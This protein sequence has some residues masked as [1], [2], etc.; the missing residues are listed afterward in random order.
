[1]SQREEWP[2]RTYGAFAFLTHD[3]LLFPN[4]STRQFEVVKLPDHTEQSD[5]D[6]E[7][8]RRIA[9]LHVS[10][11][12]RKSLFSDSDRLSCFSAPNPAGARQPVKP[13]VAPSHLPFAADSNQAIIAVQAARGGDLVLI[14][15]R[16]ALV[17]TLDAHVAQHPMSRKGLHL[18]WKEWTI[19][20]DGGTIRWICYEDGCEWTT[21][22]QRLIGIQAEQCLRIKDFNPYAVR[23]A[24]ASLKAAAVQDANSDMPQLSFAG[25]C[26]PSHNGTSLWLNDCTYKQVV[27]SGVS[28]S[29]IIE[30]G[31]E[32]PYVET[33]TELDDDAYTNVLVDGERLVCIQ[34]WWDHRFQGLDIYFL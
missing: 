14:I 32:L 29:R 5:T 12:K 34:A 18:P 31:G 15:H 16:R 20:P 19:G 7:T 9:Y 6:G 33:V 10:G 1:M 27:E 22:G 13:N 24:R 11:N 21:Y 17:A 23:R 8:L 26:H 3:L 25:T 4:L 30:I 2:S 28:L